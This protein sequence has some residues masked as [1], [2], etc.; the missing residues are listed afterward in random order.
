MF[1]V[2]CAVY[3]VFI[4]VLL[5]Y[6]VLGQFDTEKF[7]EPAF[8]QRYRGVPVT[9]A[10][11]SIT[12]KYGV[13]LHFPIWTSALAVF[14]IDSASSAKGPKK[15]QRNVSQED[16]REVLEGERG[17]AWLVI[18]EEVR[19]GPKSMARHVV[20]HVR[21]N[22]YMNPADN[23]GESGLEKWFQSSLTGKE[24]ATV[25][26]VLTGEGSDIPGVG[27]RISS[28]KDE[29]SDLRTTLDASVQRVVETVLNQSEV[30]RG[31]AVVLDVKSGDILAMASRPQ[32]DQNHPELY[33]KQPDAP[34]V[35]RA[36]LC[37]ALNLSLGRFRE[38]P[39]DTAALNILFKC[40]DQWRAEVINDRIHLEDEPS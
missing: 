24:P 21:V 19:Y 3:V 9:L 15:V 12:D 29:P 32:F 4:G 11:G 14:P 13:P 8:T 34:F 16:M 20:G 1:F 28:P 6:Q 17:K 26:V 33:L 30:E 2:S 31:A 10:R 18:P 25:G 35:N 23:V 40:G 5:R 38:V 39:Q 22:A 37:H 7:V 36:I 27:V